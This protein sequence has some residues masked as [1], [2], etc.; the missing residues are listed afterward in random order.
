[1]TGCFGYS[2]G[3]R[4]LLYGRSGGEVDL[5]VEDGASDTDETSEPLVEWFPRPERPTHARL[6]ATGDT[7]RLWTSTIGWFEI[8]PLVPL[9]RLPGP[10]NEARTEA[11]L[12]G[13]PSSLCS[14]YR[15][16]VHLH[17]AAVD[18]DGTAVLIAAPGKRGKTTLSAAFFR[19]GF[20]LLSEDQTC[21]RP[22]SPPA[23]MP[24]PASLRL[25]L[26]TM[27]ALALQGVEVTTREPDRVHLAIEE[28]LRGT[29]DPVPLRAIVLL[30]QSDQGIS[31]TPA[32]PAQVA[33]DLWS[34]SFHLPDYRQQVFFGI[35]DIVSGANPFDLTR[36][37]RFDVLD[38]VIDVVVDR[39]LA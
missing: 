19:R 22:G 11:R 12:W 27:E 16:N 25:R 5:R 31:I 28:S 21:I 7:Y 1:M 6:Y 37:L 23:V 26:D 38:E 15:G 18:V 29:Q 39:C 13:V 36:P 8:E 2:V 9:I 34:L 24:G 33:R 14:L 32:D 10:D 20:R 17:A 35:T 30:R 4:K 3:D